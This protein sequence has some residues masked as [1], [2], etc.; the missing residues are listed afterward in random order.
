MRTD[1]DRNRTA[2]DL[3]LT[4]RLASVDDFRALLQ[5]II[6]D[7]EE[8]QEDQRT[9]DENGLLMFLKSLLPIFPTITFIEPDND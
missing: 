4:G 1:I 9:D 8:Y 2:P 7:L 6:D 3:T 5:A